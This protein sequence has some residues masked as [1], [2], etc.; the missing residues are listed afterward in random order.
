MS[1]ILLGPPGA[2][3]GTQAKLLVDKRG[4]IQLST[5][6]MLRNAVLE[7]SDIGKKA[8]EIMNKGEFV[9]DEIMVDIIS[10][11]IQKIGAS[12]FILDGFPRTE[13]QAIAL[14]ELLNIKK[15][16]LF[17][18]IELKVDDLLLI[19]RITGRF[20]CDDCGAVYN[21]NFKVPKVSGVCDFCEG[22][23]F[24][25]RS[26]DSKEIMEN[27]LEAYHKHTA[28]LLA[29]YKNKELLSSVDGMA[30]SEEVER[31]ISSILDDKMEAKG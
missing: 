23:N 14:D 7:G 2:G 11:K 21:D 19:D 22:S 4:Y 16:S 17:S 25:R 1:I 15:R 31:Q 6:D 27:R 29:Y 30:S 28:P 18:V 8:K 13:G 10:D 26:D 24:S 3:K 20:T 5:G 9:P 12:N